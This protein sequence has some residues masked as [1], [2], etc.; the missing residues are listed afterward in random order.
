MVI[1]RFWGDFAFLRVFSRYATITSRADVNER[2]QQ[3][4]TRD[5]LERVKKEYTSEVIGGLLS[6]EMAAA[7][8]VCRV[9]RVRSDRGAFFPTR[10][11][12]T[13]RVHDVRGRRSRD[14]SSVCVCVAA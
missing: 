12:L 13:E 11:S 2:L 7:C 5:V 10:Q 3:Q 4:F 8:V 1:S 6:R 14:G 9:C